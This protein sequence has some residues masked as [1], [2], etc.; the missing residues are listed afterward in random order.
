MESRM[1]YIAH[2]RA[3]IDFAEK[4]AR[5]FAA[6]SNHSTYGDLEPDS[7]LAIRWGMGNDCVLVVKLD[8]DF[9]KVNFQQAV[10]DC[11]PIPKQPATIESM[12]GGKPEIGGAGNIDPINR[13]GV[14]VQGDNIVIL[15]PKPKMTRDEALSLASF[16]VVLADPDGE[17][18]Q[19]F[20]DK[21]K[22]S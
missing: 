3:L 20:L 19:R 11:E 16:L 13:H 1:T 4:A 15:F 9:G 18:F 21:V 7:Y 12:R 8:S 2:E 14:G 17:R 5:H 22:A 10:R 6:N